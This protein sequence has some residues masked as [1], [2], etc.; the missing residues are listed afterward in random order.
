MSLIGTPLP[1]EQSSGSAV[2]ESSS[3][4]LVTGA[5]AAN[6][7]DQVESGGTQ[8]RA[9]AAS[10]LDAAFAIAADPALPHDLPQALAMVTEAPARMT[11]LNDRGRIAEGLRADL[12]AVRV[13]GGQPVVEAAW[14]A[15]RQVF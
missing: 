4:P 13:I 14:R 12:V 15:G 1:S 6:T 7:L 9:V 3:R 5:E 10:P 8:E 11:C 2:E